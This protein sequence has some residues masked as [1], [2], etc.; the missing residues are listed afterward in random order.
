MTYYNDNGIGG[1]GCCDYNG[2][3][4]ILYYVRVADAGNYKG[5][6]KSL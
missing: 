1:M 2:I 5:S 4:L 3:E 6:E